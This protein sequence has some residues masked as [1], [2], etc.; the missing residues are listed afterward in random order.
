MTAHPEMR[1]VPPQESAGVFPGANPVARAVEPVTRVAVILCGWW[2]LV[3]SAF[4]VI[5]IVGRKLFGFTLQG[6]DEIGGYTLAVA[7]SLGFSHALASRA[8]TRIDF[9][10]QKLGA[11]TRAALN[12]LAMVTLALMAGFALWKG[13]PVLMESIEFQSHSTSPLQTPMWLPQGLWIAGLALFAGVAL[14]LGAHALLLLARGDHARLNA[15]YGPPSLDEE[16]AREVSALDERQ[17][18]R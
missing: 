5:E 17:A 7:A 4:T 14:A 16:I 18:G 15:F 2:L 3:I 8:H 1:P 10:I 11:G 9:L 12:A 13:L 6:V